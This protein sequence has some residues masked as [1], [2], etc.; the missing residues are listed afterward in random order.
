MRVLACC[1]GLVTA[2]GSAQFKPVVVHG[3]LNLWNGNP[4]YRITLMKERRI[5]G[6]GEEDGDTIP[7]GLRKQLVNWD[8]QIFADFTVLPL[9]PD[10][11]GRMRHVR[12]LGA[13]HIVNRRDLGSGEFVISRMAPIKPQP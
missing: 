7:D 10:R 9:E 5:L 2:I 12:I 4:T 6:V 3:R 11:K 13:D 1:L 8:K